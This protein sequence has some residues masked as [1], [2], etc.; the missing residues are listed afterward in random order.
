MYTPLQID[1]FKLFSC[2]NFLQPAYQNDLIIRKTWNAMT[3]LQNISNVLIDFWQ[4]TRIGKSWTVGLRFQVFR[5]SV[6]DSFKASM[7]KYAVTTHTHTDRIYE[8]M[9]LFYLLY[10]FAFRIW[11]QFRRCSVSFRILKCLTRKPVYAW[12]F[13]VHLCEMISI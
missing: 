4:L 12:F 8:Y 5:L 10:Y 9:N 1:L 11:Q 13:F 6:F 3:N 7:G 2:L